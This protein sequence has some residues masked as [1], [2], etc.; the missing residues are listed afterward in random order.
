[1]VEA[2]LATQPEMG[3]KRRLEHPALVSARVFRV[4]GFEKI[5]IFYR[6]VQGG[7]EVLR[8]IH[9]ARNI[10]MLLEDG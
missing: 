4:T 7:I 5:L 1:M 10:E 3:W 2:L 9:G 6:P 8:V